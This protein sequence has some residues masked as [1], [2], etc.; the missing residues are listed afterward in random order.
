MKLCEMFE[1]MLPAVRD[2][3]FKSSVFREV[4]TLITMIFVDIMTSVIMMRMRGAQLEENALFRELYLNPTLQNA[5]NF[6]IGQC[7]Y[8][9][10]IVIGIILAELSSTSIVQ[11]KFFKPIA[12]SY[13]ISYPIHL[14]LILFAFLR[15]YGAYT[16]IIEIF[17]GFPV[18]LLLV[19]ALSFF[20][21]GSLLII[22]FTLYSNIHAALPKD[23]S[24]QNADL[25]GRSFP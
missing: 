21:I 10:P 18:F 9:I 20:T 23:T 7:V 11:N 19:M 8:V 13:T 17:I 3:N 5:L 24:N 2:R 25:L 16:N 6:I 1:R 4:L 22:R 12:R 15:L 14:L